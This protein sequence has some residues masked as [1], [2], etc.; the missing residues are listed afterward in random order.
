MTRKPFTVGRHRKI[1]VVTGTNGTAWVSHVTDGAASPRISVCHAPPGGAPS[2]IATFGPD[3]RTVRFG[4]AG[5]NVGTWA[6]ALE[7]AG[8]LVA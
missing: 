3:A 5:V 8:S 4:A 7:L 6:D 1:S 2:P